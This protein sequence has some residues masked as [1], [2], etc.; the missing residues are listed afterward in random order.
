[1]R[2]NACGAD[3]TDRD[4]PAAEDGEGEGRSA[5]G[6]CVRRA[7]DAGSEER[8]RD[9]DRCGGAI[10]DACLGGPGTDSEGRRGAE[11]GR[12]D[13]AETAGR[14]R[15]VEGGADRGGDSGTEWGEAGGAGVRGSRTGVR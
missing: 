6:V 9:A 8:L 5:G 14:D 2:G 7:R 4:D 3:G 15:G 12:E 11:G 1:M 10:L 13:A